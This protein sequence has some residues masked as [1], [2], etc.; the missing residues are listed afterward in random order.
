M[1]AKTVKKLS[2]LSEVY[3]PNFVNKETGKKMKDGTDSRI[4]IEACES[5]G[6]NSRISTL[7]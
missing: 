3:Y 6:V 4:T 1:D 5:R 2:T 7:F